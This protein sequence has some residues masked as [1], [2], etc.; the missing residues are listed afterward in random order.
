M[1]KGSPWYC[2]RLWRLKRKTEKLHRA[3]E[4]A[5]SR[6]GAADR[7]FNEADY[8]WRRAV[9]GTEKQKV[10]KSCRQHAVM[11]YALRQEQL[12]RATQLLDEAIVAEDKFRTSVE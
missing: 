7:A 3:W 11:L 6:L 5:A 1:R 8:V 9:E 10:A 2:W 12:L 4:K